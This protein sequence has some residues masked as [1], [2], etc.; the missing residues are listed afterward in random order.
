MVTCNPHRGRGWWGQ[1]GDAV[2]V[3]DDGDGGRC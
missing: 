3:A 2:D 1:A